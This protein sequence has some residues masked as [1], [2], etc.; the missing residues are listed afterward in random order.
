VKVKRRQRSPIALELAD[1]LCDEMLSL[2]SRSI[3][4]AS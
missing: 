1:E 4:A 3:V 2:R